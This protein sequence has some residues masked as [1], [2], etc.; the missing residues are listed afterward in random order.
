M[1]PHPGIKSDRPFEREPE[2]ATGPTPSDDALVTDEVHLRSYIEAAL[3][4]ILAVNRKGRIVFM[5]GHTEQMFGYPRQEIIG[6]SL[7]ILVPQHLQEQY[8]A[9]LSE[10]F[11]APSVRLLGMELGLTAQRKNG[12]EFPIEIGLS[13]VEGQEGP[14]ALGFV[15]DVTERKL[16]RDELARINVALVRSNT[17]LDLFAHLVSH[18]LQEPLRVITSYLDLLHR[19]YRGKLDSTADSFIDHVIEGASRMRHQIEDLLNFSC[20]GTV[21]PALQPVPSDGILKTALET[22]QAAID[23]RSAQVSSDP[24][25]E[26]VADPN[27]LAQVFQNLIANGIKFQKDGVPLVHVSAFQQGSEWVFSVHDNGIG[28]QAKDSAR[29][30]KMFERLNSKEQ[31]PGTGLGLMICHKIMERLHGR[32]WFESKPGE[33]TTFFFSLPAADKAVSQTSGD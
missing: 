4:G 21:N 14:I 29:I 18:D 8:A 17:E 27:L 33:G 10:Y 32:I 28:I 19:R 30:F 7:M 13:F 31:Y 6:Q 16:V 15:T 25:P 2:N 11:A 12:Q 20:I 1:L 24:L 9:A 22:L 26:I 5:N 23:E 3:G